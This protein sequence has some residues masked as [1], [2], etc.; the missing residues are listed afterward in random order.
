MNGCGPECPA[1]FRAML[2]QCVEEAA[3]HPC[4][5][6]PETKLDDDE[7][8]EMSRVNISLTG[9]FWIDQTEVTVEAYREWLEDDDEQSPDWEADYCAWKTERSDPARDRS[10]CD[11]PLS[12][13]ERDAFGA[14]K[15]IRCV[16]FCD[17]DAYCRYRG[18]RLCYDFNEFG[19]TGPRGY[20]REW[21]F[22]CTNQLSTLFPW[23]DDSDETRCNT[24]QRGRACPDNSCGPTP[25][26]R[27]PDCRTPSAIYDLLGNV[28]EWTYACN[29]L[30]PEA[31][32]C[33][34]RGGGYFDPI[35]SCQIERTEPVSARLSDVGF[36]CCADLTIA[37]RAQIE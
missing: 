24:G 11:V 18:K 29:D 27:R 23:G 10:L 13:T 4:E 31:P 19:T 5:A 33:L 20:P 9:C 2:D 26:A 30:N 25:V 15:P 22:A 32:V 8:A 12:A 1:G 16:D 7:T 21:R 34:V 37:E 14:S 35:M 36:R 28:G 3:A 6:L 17:A